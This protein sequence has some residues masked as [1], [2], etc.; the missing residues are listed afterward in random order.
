[1]GRAGPRR[2]AELCDPAVQTRR[3]ATLM[4]ELA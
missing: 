3:F 4:E 2:A 1:L